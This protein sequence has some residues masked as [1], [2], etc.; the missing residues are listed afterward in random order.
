MIAISWCSAPVPL[1]RFTWFVTPV[2]F[3]G[4]V[5]IVDVDIDVGEKVP[6]T[7]KFPD[8]PTP[9]VTTKVPVVVVVEAVFDVREII[10][11]ISILFDVSIINAAFN[12]P[13]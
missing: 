3:D 4:L 7:F 13:D 8:I 9:P 12:D 10:F 11:F 5:V 1:F 6:P 2:V